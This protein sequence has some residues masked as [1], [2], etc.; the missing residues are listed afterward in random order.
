MSHD[1]TPCRIVSPSYSAPWSYSC[2]RAHRLGSTSFRSLHRVETL[3]LSDGTA[4][5][6]PVSLAGDTAVVGGG[7]VVHVFERESGGDHWSQTAT[8]VASDGTP[9]FGGSRG[10][11]E[12]G[13]TD[14][15]GPRD[16]PGPRAESPHELENVLARTLGRACG[17]RLLQ[18]KCSRSPVSSG[19]SSS[20]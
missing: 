19:T 15:A 9:G 11:P 18:S 4:A 16:R 8:L 7:G 1:R 3:T 10:C 12:H 6:G 20:S 14:P 17:R 2:N 13:E 5:A